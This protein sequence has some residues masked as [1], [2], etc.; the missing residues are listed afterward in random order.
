MYLTSKLGNTPA[1]F[2][3]EKEKVYSWK[4]CWAALAPGKRQSG[5]WEPWPRGACIW[6]HIPPLSSSVISGVLPSSSEPQVP[7]I[8]NE[9]KDA[10]LNSI[11]TY[12]FFQVSDTLLEIQWWIRKTQLPPRDR[13]ISGLLLCVL[14]DIGHTCSMARGCWEK[15][16]SVLV[17]HS[18]TSSW[19]WAN[20]SLTTGNLAA[21][22]L[23]L[24]GVI[25]QNIRRL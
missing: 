14:R 22:G 19:I 3:S 6:A 23:G 25:L 2:S 21:P 7:L 13:C 18:K 8:R 17:F 4:D 1:L 20:D 12:W 9:D 10:H 24:K 15:N 16:I 11:N 5:E